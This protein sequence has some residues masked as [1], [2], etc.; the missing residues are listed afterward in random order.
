MTYLKGKLPDMS[1]KSIAHYF[2]DK[3]PVGQ[4]ETLKSIAAGI[5]NKEIPVGSTCSG[6][7]TTGMVVKALF[8]AINEKFNTNVKIRCMFAVENHPG[9]QSFILEAHGDQL[10]HLFADVSC[11]LGKRAFCLKKQCYVDVP[12]VF[13][14]VSS[15]SCVNLS[16]QRTDRADFA[17][18]YAP[19]SQGKSESG[20][21]Y[22][23][24]YK[25]ATQRTKAEVTI[26]E[27]VKDAAAALKDKDKVPQKPAV[28]II[29]EE[30]ADFNHTFE[31]KKLCSSHFLLPQRR[32]RVWG[33][34]VEGKDE[35]YGLKMKLTLQRFKSPVRFPLESILDKSLPQEMPPQ[36]ET[37][38]KH[39]ETIE[40]VCQEKNIS[41]GL[42]TFDISTSRTRHPEWAHDLL[43]CIRPSHK[44]WLLGE[45]RYAHPQ[46]LVRAHG[47]FASEFENPQALLNIDTE[48]CKDMAGN[49][50]STTVLM[51][52]IL[53]SI[54]NGAPWLHLANCHQANFAPF[55]HRGLLKACMERSETLK[56]SSSEINCD[57]DPPQMTEPSQPAKK[58]SKKP[59]QDS[60]A[61]G[62]KRK[63][64]SP[65][66]EPETE[67]NQSSTAKKSK[68]GGNKNHCLTIAKKLEILHMYDELKRTTK[69]PEKAVDG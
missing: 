59:D 33:S 49:A 40:K 7:A 48:L 1:L 26:Y 65:D 8:A 52:N 50:F 64:D 27:N 63:A 35:H 31:H 45:R 29:E 53:A 10:E 69:H 67:G 23:Y 58:K 44:I 25:A 6:F 18:C 2:I 34:S 9:K 36:S 30:F 66:A 14:L 32:E 46:E 68:R 11:F 12:K 56:R 21:T 51:A 28:K 42:A 61:K 39:I 16:G 43:T 47:L 57:E 24:G 38:Q 19:G 62:K 22:S 37:A 5:R 3:L 15:P 13:L 54:V 41:K 55:E 17:D 20:M 4:L 60:G